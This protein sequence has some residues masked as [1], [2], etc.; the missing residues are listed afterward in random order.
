VFLNYAVCN[1]PNRPLR[2]FI[3]FTKINTQQVLFAWPDIIV[4]PR[5]LKTF[6]MALWLMRS[7]A[8]GIPSGQ[9]WI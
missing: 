6:R 8:K 4:K 1:I 9:M 5:E 7:Y 3:G 2:G